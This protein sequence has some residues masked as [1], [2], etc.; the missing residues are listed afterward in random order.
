LKRTTTTTLALCEVFVSLALL[1]SIPA[2]ASTG[3]R[4]VNAPRLTISLA[5]DRADGTPTQILGGATLNPIPFHWLH[6][7][8]VALLGSAVIS[9]SV[10]FPDVLPDFAQWHK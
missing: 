3:V 10:L 1:T 8:T 4:T 5:T 2:Y 6:S 7:S 9:A